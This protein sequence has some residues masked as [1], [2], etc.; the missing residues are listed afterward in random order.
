MF[1]H[2]CTSS[3]YIPVISRQPTVLRILVCFSR[4]FYFMISRRNCFC[5]D[6]LFLK[7]VVLMCHRDTLILICFCCH[8]STWCA[9]LH[10]NKPFVYCCCLLLF[11][12]VL[13]S[14]LERDVEC[15]PSLCPCLSQLSSQLA[16]RIAS[17]EASAHDHHTFNGIQY[18]YTSVH[19]FSCSVLRMCICTY[20]YSHAYTDRGYE[21]H[22]RQLMPWKICVF[23]N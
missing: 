10:V 9:L 11:Y 15:L 23:Y 14:L 2:V 20:I 4:L 5:N 3:L 13:L 22:R 19:S 18:V 7:F 21:S 16:R 8:F 12:Q 6:Q 1:K 17:L